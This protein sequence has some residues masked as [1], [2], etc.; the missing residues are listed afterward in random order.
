MITLTTDFGASE[1][2]GAMKGV[3]YSIDP[4]ILVV[5]ISHG[6]R[7]FD[8]RQGAYVIYSTYHYFPKKSIHVVV[9]DPGVGTLRRGI[10]IEADGHFFI[11]PDNGV[12]SLIE[13]ERVFEIPKTDAGAT[14]HGR[15][16]FAPAAARIE[17]GSQPEELGCEIKGYIRLMKKEVEASYTIKGEVYCTD[18]FGNIITNIRQDHLQNAGFKV[19]DE[20]T[21]HIDG[22]KFKMPFVRTYGELKEWVLGALV[23]SSGHFEITVR[24]GSAG[25]RIK[26]TGGEPVEVFP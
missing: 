22:R 4:K 2:V 15:D 1:Y 6:I 10:I 24:E 7:P 14:F 21:V 19:G 8:I 26:I 13:A 11:G 25:E 23:N 3:I 12:F 9:V 16:V 20:L 18:R 5:D 17:V